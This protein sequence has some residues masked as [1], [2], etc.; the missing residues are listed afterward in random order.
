M[1]MDITMLITVIGVL[2]ALTNIIVEVVKKATWDK[3]PTNIVAIIVAVVLT[4]GA[5]IAYAQINAIALTWYIIAGLII[6]GIMV[7]YA[8]MFG[9]DKLQEILGW[10]KPVDK[11]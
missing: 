6:G 3:V 7:A 9:F 2:V 11:K 1:F 4:V 10:N 8:A 5:G